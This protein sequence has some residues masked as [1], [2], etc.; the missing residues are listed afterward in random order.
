ME[1]DPIVREIPVYLNRLDN[2]EADFYVLQYPLRPVYRPYGDHGQLRLIQRRPESKRLKFTYALNVE[3]AQFDEGAKAQINSLL[4]LKADNK[5]S[6]KDEEELDALSLHRLDST[7]A[8]NEGQCEYA[9][10][11]MADDAFFLTPVSRVLQ[12]RPDF[13]Y[14]D[15]AT[16]MAKVR[17]KEL[18]SAKTNT[19]A[20][21]GTPDAPTVED[22]AGVKSR[23]QETHAEVWHKETDETLND[24]DVF[25]DADSPESADILGMLKT[26]SV[27]YRQDIDSV[28]DPQANLGDL[29]GFGETQPV[30]EEEKPKG[31]AYE[32]RN[33]KV[34]AHHPKIPHVLFDADLQ[35]YLDCLCSGC[36]ESTLA[37]TK[38]DDANAGVQTGPLSW[39]AL[40]KLTTEEQVERII[41]VRQ[42]ETYAG[43]KQKLTSESAPGSVILAALDKCAYPL[44][45]AWVVKSE[46]LFSEVTSRWTQLEMLSRELLLC[47]MAN[48]VPGKNIIEWKNK[49]AL[50][51]ERINAL[52]QSLYTVKNGQM[53]SKVV[54]DP[55]FEEAH[56]ALYQAAISGPLSRNRA[57]TLYASLE[58]RA[59]DEKAR[60]N[61][62]GVSGDKVDILDRVL[63]KKEVEKA[64]KKVGA[65]TDVFI[66]DVIK[67]GLKESIETESKTRL[68]AA[69]TRV[70]ERSRILEEVGKRQQALDK[71]EPADLKD[72][73][74]EI[75]DNV[76]SLW[77]L[78]EL[79]P[80]LDPY[81]KVVVEL[82]RKDPEV[83][84]TK[85]DFMDACA[86]I[87]KRRPD[88]TDLAYRQIF[89]E[90]ALN[91]QGYWYFKA[92]NK[93]QET[94]KTK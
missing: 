70:V 32:I 65:S 86:T 27:K 49:S 82:F 13:G 26:F 74:I 72:L 11:F 25:F 33:R 75:A 19:V 40:N 38:G 88:L 69:A 24:V 8:K 62:A 3:G 37:G 80:K 21:T 47:F 39:L 15:R 92:S 29:L 64:L 52:I 36:S 48:N 5:L 45:G 23:M 73:L 58:E 46:V 30:V 34:K 78:K 6:P 89:R 84:I 85:K 81:R 20:S 61:S 63:V 66:C 54:G 1:D 71:L 94:E 56:K 22:D 9:M 17:A 87:L 68:A 42:I 35:G 55:E 57:G 53:V 14:I 90:V 59:K 12:F 10:G 41:K 77:I 93:V 51:A 67:S 76:S 50:P 4:A 83:G 79:D 18:I 43:V 31:P 44:K 2:Q 7:Y 16:E 60:L 28:A 91:I